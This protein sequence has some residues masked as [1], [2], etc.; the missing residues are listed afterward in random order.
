MVRFSNGSNSTPPK[1][2]NR[3]D[4]VRPM[5]LADEISPA[6]V[7]KMRSHRKS[8]Q[9]VALPRMVKPAGIGSRSSAMS[10]ELMFDWN[11]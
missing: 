3:S 4:L 10:V 5:V 2:E 7:R 8:R 11:A 1:N 6:L 9:V